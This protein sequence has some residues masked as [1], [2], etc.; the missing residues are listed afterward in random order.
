MPCLCG[1]AKFFTMKVKFLQ[2]PTGYGLGYFPGDV[3]E[4]ELDLVAKLLSD[5]VAELFVDPEDTGEETPPAPPEGDPED[6][7]ERT[8]TPAIED[9]RDKMPKEKR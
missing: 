3:A 7:G 6:T 5:G 8:F 9:R 4:V 2:S 1:T